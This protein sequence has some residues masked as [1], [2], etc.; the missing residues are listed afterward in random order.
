MHIVWRESAVRHTMCTSV[1]PFI[2]SI[3]DQN[4][5]SI[6]KFYL[7]ETVQDLLTV[8]FRYLLRNQPAMFLFLFFNFKD[9]STEYKYY[10]FTFLQ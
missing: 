3:N 9:L 4:Q 1:I 2:P 7:S 8:H 10:N 6:L 5:L